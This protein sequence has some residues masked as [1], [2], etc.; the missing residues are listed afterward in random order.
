MDNRATYR[1]ALLRAPRRAA[2]GVAGVL[3]LRSRV[4][5]RW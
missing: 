1:T 2:A 5:K 3:L 4:R